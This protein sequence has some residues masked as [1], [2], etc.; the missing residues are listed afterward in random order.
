M[1]TPLCDVKMS[2][3]D[4]H[5]PRPDQW[6]GWTES[7]RWEGRLSCRPLRN[8]KEE[9]EEEGGLIVPG[10][11]D[12]LVAHSNE[13]EEDEE[14]GGLIVPPTPPIGGK[15]TAAPNLSSIG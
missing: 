2:E 4:H 5:S 10:R 15:K 14:E 9:D 6:T 3:P 8:E 12:F 13:K 1:M 11:G 7:A